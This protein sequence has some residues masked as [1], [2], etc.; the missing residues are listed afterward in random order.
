[1][2]LKINKLIILST[3]LLTLIILMV[4]FRHVYKYAYKEDFSNNL[5]PTTLIKDGNKLLVYNP[6]LAKVPGVNPIQLNDLDD[7]E[8]YLEWQRSNNVHCPI[9]H[10]DKVFDQ[11]SEMYSIKSSFDTGTGGRLNHDLPFMNSYGS[12]CNLGLY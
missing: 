3:T 4:G 2:K 1:M 9:L 6:N 11:S 10:L 8:K 7:Y 12:D 5:C